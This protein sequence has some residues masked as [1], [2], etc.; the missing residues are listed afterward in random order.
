MEEAKE[1]K[2]TE[3]M[4]KTLTIIAIVAACLA[5]IVVFLFIFSTFNIKLE[6][7]TYSTKTDLDQ[8]EI[9][10]I[11]KERCE[12]TFSNIGG[13]SATSFMDVDVMQGKY[14][15][16]GKILY[17]KSVNKPLISTFILSD[18]YKSMVHVGDGNIYTL[19]Q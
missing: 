3:K 9:Y 8:I 16:D 10:F 5:L 12:I 13:G 14:K 11:D 18:D 1:N 4:Y 2:K 6:G 15:I 19:K 7:K 17:I